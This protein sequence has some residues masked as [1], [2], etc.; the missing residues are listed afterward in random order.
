MELLDME[1]RHPLLDDDDMWRFFEERGRFH[2]LLEQ[3]RS[4]LLEDSEGD[5]FR[6]AVQRAL[7]MI[8]EDAGDEENVLENSLISSIEQE[9]AQP[10]GLAAACFRRLRSR[11]VH[12]LPGLGEKARADEMLGALED[13]GFG[14]TDTLIAEKLGPLLQS[15]EP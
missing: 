12:Q 13:I 14:L 6:D 9:L 11:T 10:G 3:T 7:S 5:P 1:A 8:G 15:V 4:A 2:D